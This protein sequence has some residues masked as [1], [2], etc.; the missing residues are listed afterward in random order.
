MKGEIIITIY[1]EE[2]VLVPLVEKSF[3]LFVIS[4][5]VIL[6]KRRQLQKT[7]KLFENLVYA[8]RGST[9]YDY[10]VVRGGGLPRGEGKFAASCV[11]Y[12]AVRRGIPPRRA[13]PPHRK[14]AT[15]L[16]DTQKHRQKHTQTQAFL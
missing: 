12:H 11:L 1:M 9:V 16:T 6:I 14:C 8:T 3:S 10:R 4:I 2:F 7:H 13:A 15:A 5:I